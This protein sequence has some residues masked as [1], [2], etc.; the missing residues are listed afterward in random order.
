MPKTKKYRLNAET[1]AY[2]AV[3]TPK[4]RHI[5]TVLGVVVGSL[6][7]YVLYFYIYVAVLGLPQ[8]KTY[9]LQRKNTEW[10]SRYELMNHR[11]DEYS[12]QLNEMSRR[13]DDVYRSVFGMKEISPAVR[14]GGISGADRYERFEPLPDSSLLVTTEKRMDLL[15]KKAYVQSRSF[16]DVLALAAKAGDMSLSV[17]SI[18]P[19]YPDDKIRYSSSFGYRVDPK[20]G[21]LARHTGVDLSTD[22]G[23]PVYATGDGLVKEV[24]S[25]K[26]GYGNYIIIDHGFGYKTRYAHLHTM[27]AQRGQSVHRGDLIAYS[28]NSGK[29]TGPHLHYEVMYRDKYV[30]PLNYMDMNMPLEDYRNCVNIVPRESGTSGRRKK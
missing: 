18:C 21:G 9:L 11:M 29:S 20:W 27:V 14:N 26:R 2:E 16:D 13:D 22:I 6:A 24:V 25:E 10:S 7:L 1:L 23:N 12:S 19:L 15:T 8:P 28:G 5:L 30:N 4:G 17:P 3:K